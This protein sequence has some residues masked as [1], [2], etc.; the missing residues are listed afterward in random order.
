MATTVAS[1]ASRRRA[2][3]SVPGACSGSAVGIGAFAA[4]SPVSMRTIS[5]AWPRRDSSCAAAR[6]LWAIE[7]RSLNGVA[8]AM[9][10]DHRAINCTDG[11]AKSEGR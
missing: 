7:D 8:H 10:I 11:L 1:N 5:T 2:V 9:R 6:L 3:S 4:A